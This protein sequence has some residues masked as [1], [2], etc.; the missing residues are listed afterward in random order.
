MSYNESKAM[1]MAAFFLERAGGR[2][3]DIKLMKLMYLAEREALLKMNATVTGDSFVIMMHGQVLSN[4]LRRMSPH[5]E[6]G[7]DPALIWRD[8]ILPCESGTDNE[9]SLRKSAPSDEFLSKF[10]LSLLSGVWDE[11]S[12]M[13]KWQIRDFCHKLPECQEIP[14]GRIPLDVADILYAEGLSQEEVQTRLAD[15][16]YFEKVDEVFQSME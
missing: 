1:A 5:L 15:Q 6:A 16:R 12:G 14:S 7:G 11:F 8:Y 9:I 13:D 2:L 4:T 10:E 3:N